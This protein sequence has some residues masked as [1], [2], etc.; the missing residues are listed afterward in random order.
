MPI[1]KLSIFVAQS[2]QARKKTRAS[3]LTEMQFLTIFR[4]F[5][6]REVEY[7]QIILKSSSRN[8]SVPAVDGT[9]EGNFQ[10]HS[11]NNGEQELVTGR[12]CDID[13]IG[14]DMLLMGWDAYQ[15]M[16]GSMGPGSTSTVEADL[17]WNQWFGWTPPMAHLPED[18]IPTGQTRGSIAAMTP[19]F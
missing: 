2:M 10:Y 7:A 18:E 11:R 3:T 1:P 4:S 19:E 9:L 8:A 6:R 13:L 17:F 15:S 12:K 14:Q 5:L 16:Y